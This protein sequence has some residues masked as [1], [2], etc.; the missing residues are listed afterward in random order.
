MNEVYEV[1]SGLTG[2]MLL[3]EDHRTL[4]LGWRVFI[5]CWSYGCN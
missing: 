1:G 3:C 5:R 2:A 4:A